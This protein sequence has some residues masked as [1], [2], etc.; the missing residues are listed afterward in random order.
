MTT[1]TA[2]AYTSDTAALQGWDDADRVMLSALRNSP[3]MGAFLDRTGY[4]DA[5]ARDGLLGYVQSGLVRIVV[6]S[7]VRYELTW[8]GR[9]RLAQ[10][11]QRSTAT[12]LRKAA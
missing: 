1:M 7:G 5:I 4:S 8:S 3:T 6:D 2:L 11:T 9:A 12:S 10:L